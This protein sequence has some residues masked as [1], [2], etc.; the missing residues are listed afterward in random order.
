[1]ATLQCIK[2]LVDKFSSEYRHPN[3]PPI[4]ESEIYT[5]DSSNEV[6]GAESFWPETWPN[7]D[8]KGVYA[9]FSHDEVLYIGKASLQILGYRLGSYFGYSDDRKSA[10]TKKG[11]YW[12]KPPTSIV[13]WSVPEKCFFEASALEEFLIFNLKNY[14]PDNR[15]GTN[16]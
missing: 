14:L 13:T 16:T 6:K 9:I 15:V 8:Y 2:K 4:V 11:H 5:L 7:N 3:L 12:S 1:M 10:V